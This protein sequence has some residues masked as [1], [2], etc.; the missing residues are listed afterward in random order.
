MDERD[1]RGM[2]SFNFKFLYLCCPKPLVGD[3]LDVSARG[4][5]G[6]LT[7][8]ASDSVKGDHY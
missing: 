6:D 8:I 5:G 4:F 3:E 1:E 2:Y 7:K